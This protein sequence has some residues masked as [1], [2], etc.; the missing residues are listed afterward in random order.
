MKLEI[1]LCRQILKKIEEEGGENGLQKF[2]RIENVEDNLVF[3]QIKKMQEAGYVSYKVY[4]KGLHDQFEYFKVDATFYG[5]EFLRQMMDNTIWS[6]TKEIIKKKGIDL[7]F[8]TVKLA[9]PLAI[10]AIFGAP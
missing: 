5:H 6:K 4:G 10:K 8:D 1:D 2:P 7:T 3:Y 9:I